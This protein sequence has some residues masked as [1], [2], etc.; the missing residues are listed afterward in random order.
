M[1][2]KIK[3]KQRSKDVKVMNQSR[4]K[5]KAPTTTTTEATAATTTTTAAATEPATTIVITEDPKV[6]KKT[7]AAATVSEAKATT[8]T[9]ETAIDTE[10][11]EALEA[12]DQ[13]EEEVEEKEEEEE[14]SEKK[15]EEEDNNDEGIDMGDMKDELP[16]VEVWNPA[17]RP[18]EE[19]EE[20]IY[21]PSAYD[22]LHRLNSE[23][24]CL[25]FDILR[26]Q[27]GQGRSKF[28]HTMYLA[29]GT[30]A[31]MAK[32][33][34]ISIMKL[35]KLRR[36]KHD[37]RE[38]KGDDEEDSDNEIIGDDEEVGEDELVDEDPVVEVRD[39]KHD[40][41]V[42]RIRSNPRAPSVLATWAD[43]GKVFLW[44]AAPWLRALDAPAAAKLPVA[45]PLQALNHRTEGFAL[46]WASHEGAAGCLLTGDCAGGIYLWRPNGSG[47]G[48]SWAG[49]GPFR[50]HSGSVE[51]L[52]WS[53]AEA[54]VFASCSTDQTIRIWDARQK[55]AAAL[56]VCHAHDADVNVISWNRF[57]S[58][59]MASGADDG[60]FRVWD[61][62][63]LRDNA[64]I[65][66]FRYHPRAITSI[67]WSSYDESTLAVASADN[68]ISVWDLSLEEDVE[69]DDAD[70]EVDNNGMVVP[71]QLMFIHMGQSDI[72]E[73]HW[74]PQIPKT[75]VSTAY[76]GF[77]IFK[78]ENL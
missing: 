42:N 72:K 62:R 61:L 16:E 27:L 21:E 43:T 20:L 8:T 51:D 49:E 64:P 57:Q 60:A 12:E 54:A 50:G 71:P 58:F 22:M 67:E 69:T 19:G 76:D 34:K 37:R 7:E 32:H 55:H 63:A 41:G 44:D 13:Y 5:R 28:P 31:D 6:A 26:D 35:S 14:D 38:D 24:P 39:M 77:N 15:G 78:P 59:L 68:S 70:Q 33:N 56:R 47:N 75:I 10:E 23:W 11:P 65:T 29:A 25:S 30:Q 2:R 66:D 45:R 53:P 40:G 74:H 73:L 9:T 36:T 1:H 46:D 4:E 3:L 48:S 18:L 52:Q 17:T